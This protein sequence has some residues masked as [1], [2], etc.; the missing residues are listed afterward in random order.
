[1][2]DFVALA[3]DL[4]VAGFSFEVDDLPSVLAGVAES[5]LAASL[6]FSLR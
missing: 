3:S 6:Y 5:F 4:V 1:V 2:V